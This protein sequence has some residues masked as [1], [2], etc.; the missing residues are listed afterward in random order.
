MNRLIV[1]L[2]CLLPLGSEAQSMYQCTTPEGTKVFQQLP[3]VPGDAAL[4]LKALS[5]GKGTGLSEDAREFL[6]NV[7][8]ERAAQ[9]EANRVEAERQE[10]LSVERAKVRAAHRA[11][12]A[13][14][15]TAA[16]IRATIPVRR[17]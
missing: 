3:C 7:D 17:R 14:K 11:A 1:S 13:Q 8:Q 15:S 10:A 6:K 9:A 12:A 16:A 4:P 2:F 5:N